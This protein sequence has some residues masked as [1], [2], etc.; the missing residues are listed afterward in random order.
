M[1]DEQLIKLLIDGDQSAYKTLVE[2]YKDMV[3]GLCFSYLN[4]FQD[5]EDTSQEV[6]IQVYRSIGTFKQQSSLKTW[7]YRITISKCQ[8][9]IKS[10]NRKKRFAFLTGYQE[11]EER[12]ESNAQTPQKLLE[13]KEHMALLHQAIDQLSD[14]QR[15]IFI[16][17]HIQ[18]KTNSEISELLQMPKSTV[19]SHIK[20][21]KDRVKKILG[22]L[23]S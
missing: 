9:F 10:R 17:N 20:R 22:N 21:G 8:D 1:Q 16:L 7:I 3:Y 13:N 12:W 2:S 18:G 5:S 23:I 15:N 14:V 19:D 4:N 6:F 11:V